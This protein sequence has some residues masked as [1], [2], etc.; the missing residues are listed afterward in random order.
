MS[1]RK[2][3]HLRTRYTVRE[4]LSETKRRVK[5]PEKNEKI[6]IIPVYVRPR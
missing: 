3:S 6:G 4:V 5:Y 2:T 1:L